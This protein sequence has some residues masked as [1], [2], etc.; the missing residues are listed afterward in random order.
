[1]K[2]AAMVVLAVAASL[3]GCSR[4][5]TTIQLTLYDIKV[6]CSSVGSASF[7]K[8]IEDGNGDLTSV[9]RIRDGAVAQCELEYR[10]KQQEASKPF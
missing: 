8:A 6:L 9:E 2:T 10:I 4:G 1:M 5:D 3:T 7:A